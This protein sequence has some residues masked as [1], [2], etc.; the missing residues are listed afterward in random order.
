MTKSVT[1]F[2]NSSILEVDQAPKY[3]S[4]HN[5]NEQRKKRFEQRH[6]Y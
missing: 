5:R 4:G 2:T 1:V 6:K 3:V